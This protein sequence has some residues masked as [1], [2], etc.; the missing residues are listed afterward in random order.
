MIYED[1][2]FTQEELPDGEDE[3]IAEVVFR[4]T[5]VEAGHV[6]FQASMLP[7][8]N[9]EDPNWGYPTFEVRLSDQEFKQLCK[10][11]MKFDE[12]L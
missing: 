12:Q 1:L 3:G 5:A 9:V 6:S 7:D 10:M 2:K 11:F 8:E 4:L